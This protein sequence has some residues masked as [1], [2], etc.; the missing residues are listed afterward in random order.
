MWQNASGTEPT[1]SRS[2]R[3]ALTH[4][5]EEKPVDP[6]GVFPVEP[7]P[8]AETATPETATGEPTTAE[9]GTAASEAG[10]A[11]AAGP[12]PHPPRAKARH[13]ALVR[14]FR[15]GRAIEGIVEKVVKGGYEVRLG[16]ARGFCPHSQIDVQR[17]NEPERQIG[18]TYQFKITELRRG[19]E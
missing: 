7:A 19:G 10:E 1:G 3:R 4:A 15:A 5:G 9:A 18:Q 8:L 16:R 6:E 13:P 12:G 17:E 2:R 14:A 11:A